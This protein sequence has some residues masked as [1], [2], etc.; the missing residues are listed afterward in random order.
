MRCQKEPC[1]CLMEKLLHHQALCRKESETQT[2]NH[3]TPV[4][5]CCDCVPSSTLRFLWVQCKVT[6]ISAFLLTQKSSLC[7]RR[8]ELSSLLSCMG[9]QAFCQ[10]QYFP[11][12][13]C[14]NRGL[15]KQNTGKSH[16]DRFNQLNICQQTIC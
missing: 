5:I 11:K 16:Q 12:Y 3:V 15:S 10:M 6:A 7:P 4:S 13:F 9:T 8:F 1:Y 2:V 14:Q